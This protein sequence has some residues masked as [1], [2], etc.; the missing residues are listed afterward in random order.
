MKPPA[1]LPQ[2]LKDAPWSVS[3]SGENAFRLQPSTDFPGH[4]VL[5]QRQDPGAGVPQ[6]A[7][8]HV[9]RQRRGMIELLCH[10]CGEPTAPDDRFV[11]PVASGGMVTLHDGAEQ[12]GCNVPPMHLTCAERALA[13][14]PHLSRLEDRPLRCE[15]DD[16]RLI[17][18]TDVT[19]G[20]ERLAY[21]IPAGTKVVYSCYR[22]YGPA[23]TQAVMAARAVWEEEARARRTAE[24]AGGR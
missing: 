6:F 22:L 23:F 19:P 14:C 5:D 10:V 21:E 4:A 11:F 3:W 1:D 9:T 2:S 20:L 16:G 8:I 17:P 24:K 15:G 7:M 18:R 13:E 12:W